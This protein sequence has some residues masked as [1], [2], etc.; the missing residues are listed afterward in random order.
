[1]MKNIETNEVY[2]FK[3]SSGEELVAKVVSIGDN[4]IEL[5]EPLSVAPNAQGM[6]LIPSMFT[7]EKDKNITLNTSTVTMYAE[8]ADNLR[9]KYIEATTGITT[10]S[11]KIVLG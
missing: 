5:S 3:L 8:T 9:I 10:S 7:S 4:T 1:M 6:G 11:K 2:S